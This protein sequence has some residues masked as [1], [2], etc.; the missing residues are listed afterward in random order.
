MLRCCGQPHLHLCDTAGY[1][2]FTGELPSGSHG[3]AVRD[4]WG[5]P[6]ASQASPPLRFGAKACFVQ[7]VASDFWSDAQATQ[8]HPKFQLK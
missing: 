6:L 8:T 5:L 7:D 1:S 4:G 3:C 2:D